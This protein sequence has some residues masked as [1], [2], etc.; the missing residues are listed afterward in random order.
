MV[1]LFLATSFTSLVRAEA[2]S[3]TYT[4]QPGDSLWKVASKFNTTVNY[5]R[6]LNNYW[7]SYITAGQ[8]L[9]VPASEATSTEQKYTV[10]VGDTIWKISQRFNISFQVI[11]DA[12]R[13]VSDEIRPG[14]VLII[15]GNTTAPTKSINYTQYELDMLA[16]VIFAESRGEPYLGQVAVGAV[17]VNRV[18]AP[19][20]PKSIKDVLFQDLAFESMINGEYSNSKPDSFAYR[21]ALAALNGEDPTA[22]ALYFFNP[23]KVTNPKSWV[24]TRKIVLRIGNHVFGI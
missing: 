10:Q 24:W 9:R 3:T 17:I 4:V 12:N 8:V 6:Q 5:L 23:D 21:A 19:G 7:A 14:Q 18:K 1:A 15:P 13:L 2:A 22:G 16:R 20:F 11:K